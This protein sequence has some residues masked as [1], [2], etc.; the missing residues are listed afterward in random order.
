M[1]RPMRVAAV[2]ISILSLHSWIYHVEPAASDN[3]SSMDGRTDRF[4][5]GGAALCGNDLCD[6][7]EDVY[8]CPR[9]CGDLR[10][11]TADVGGAKG[12]AGFA[13]S[14]GSVRRDVVV[15]SLEVYS[16][17]ARSRVSVETPVQVYVRDGHHAGRELDEEGWDLVY[18]ETNVDLRGEFE[19]TSLGG[20]NVS[21]PA[22]SIRSFFVYA[23]D[24]IRYDRGT[25]EGGVFFDDGMLQ[26]YEGVGVR[27]KLS[28]NYP[29]DIFSA[30][31]FTGSIT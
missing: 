21:I 19:T 5:S 29:E 9:D 13:F 15:N 18:D 11:T 6:S 20:L 10:L 4:T 22:G 3:D 25:G 14:V 12:A 17:L 28:G 8:A 30:R 26:V 27:N 23:S 24:K 1:C 31:V 2:L 16:R 7:L